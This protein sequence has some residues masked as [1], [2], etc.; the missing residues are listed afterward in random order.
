MGEL[1][2]HF[3]EDGLADNTIVVHWSD[4]G[5]M[6]RGKR[7]PYDQGIRSPMIIRWPVAIAPDVGQT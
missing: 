6:P 2:S 4:H 3:E 7:F 1:L 5:P